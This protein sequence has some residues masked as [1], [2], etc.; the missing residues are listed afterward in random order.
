M[1]DRID[2]YHDSF[3]QGEFCNLKSF[4]VATPLTCSVNKSASL[5][6]YW[7]ENQAELRRGEK[8]NSF[9][10][11]RSAFEIHSSFSTNWRQTKPWYADVSSDVLQQALRHQDQAFNNF[12]SGR[13]KF[14]RFKKNR[15]LGIEF[16][17]GT[18]RIQ[19]NRIK[20]PKLGWMKFAKSRNIGDNWEI[21]TVTITSDIDDWY[22]SILLR[23]KT[24][25]DYYQKTEDQL[26]TI[27]GCDVGIK[28][29]TAFS[30]SETIP[31]PNIGKQLERRLRIRQR[32]L[33]RKKKGSNNWKK[34]GKIVAKV[35]RDIR[36]RRQD[37][38]W[39]LGKK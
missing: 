31:N 32:R 7:K 15:D 26:N 11:R 3:K 29:I 34:A 10:P 14:P 20:F 22:V 25:P 37:F 8:N 35:H 1:T 27:I 39:K 4:G 13:A 5:G 2:S 18:V 24:I 23:D 6:N 30:S 28:K 36:R 21:R 12:F 33:S 19:K 9:N 16:K 17:P 38:Q